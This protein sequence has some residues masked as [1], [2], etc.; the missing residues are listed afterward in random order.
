MPKYLSIRSTYH[1]I[2]LVLLFRW[3]TSENTIPCCR[4]ELDKVETEKGNL[5]RYDAVGRKFGI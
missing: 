4:N 1:V 3:K 5:S 2:L